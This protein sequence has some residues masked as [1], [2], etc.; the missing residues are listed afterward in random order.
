MI[1]VLVVTHGQICQDLLR[2]NERIVG[3]S[4]HMRALCVE[5]DEDTIA[6]RE[7]IREAV[8]TLDTGSGVLILTDMFGGT[9]TNIA[10]SFLD[11]KC[12]EIVTGVNLPM[13]LKLSNL[14]QEQSL[15]EIAEAI[16][17]KGRQSIRIARN[18]FDTL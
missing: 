17:E 11:E 4:T 10:L 8:E 12:V 13:L 16:S 9:P 2:V 6:V 5:W 14:P 1:G 18:I 7:R 15:R 3:K